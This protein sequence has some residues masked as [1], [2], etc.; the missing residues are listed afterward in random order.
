MDDHR[1]R[2]ASHGTETD[3][4]AANPLFSVETHGI[5]HIPERERRLTVPD[6]AK[7]WLGANLAPFILVLGIIGY[8]LGLPVWLLIG[9]LAVGVA[10]SYLAVGLG[11]I[12]GA[13]S[14][15]PTMQVSIVA[16]GQGP[17]RVNAALSWLVSIAFEVINAVTGVLAVVTLFDLLGWDTSD[18]VQRVVA[19]VVVFFVSVAVAF[20]GHATIVRLQVLAGYGL[21]LAALVL[22]A[23]ALTGA[24]LGARSGEPLDAATTVVLA[25]VF[26]GLTVATHTAY[27]GLSSD[28]SRYLPGRTPGRS[29]VGA[30]LLGAGVPA[31][32][33]GATGILLAAQTDRDLTANPFDL[34]GAL[35]T[36][37]FAVFLVAAITGTVM[38]NALTV[39]SGGLCAQAAGLRIPRSR[40]VLVDAVLGTL[41][42]VWVLFVSANVLDTINDAVVFVV[43]WNAPWATVWLVDAWFRRGVSTTGEIVGSR[44][45]SR[46]RGIIAQL[47]GTIVAALSISVPSYTGP[48]A[49]LFG[50]ADLA[51][52]LGP[53]VAL[54]VFLALREKVSPVAPSVV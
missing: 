10:V 20:L 34:Q 35:P 4:P 36:W 16:V 33:L 29:I 23:F 43:V 38:N 1:T 18:T 21:G 22:F 5:D 9:L 46:W 8:T 52:L 28:V 45:S 19:L 42:I 50:G 49:A 12:P 17:G 47:A 3:N 13:R 53:A 40:A 6:L 37:I 15:I 51:W 2:S 14:G 44:A 32:V 27:M 41:G 11:G 26:L 7:A 48:L 54:T 39:Y 25:V 31:F 30:T 24:E